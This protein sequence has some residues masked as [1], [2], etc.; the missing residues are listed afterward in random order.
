MN[1]IEEQKT[2]LEVLQS[3]FDGDQRFVVISDNKFQ[4]KFGQDGDC[5]S[6]ILE[7]S[8]PDTYP[9]TVPDISLD[10]FY[11]RHILSKVK[12]DIKARLLAE[13]KQY[14]GMAVTFTLFEYIRE[15]FEDLVKD[16]VEIYETDNY[17]ELNDSNSE[18]T[19]EDEVQEIT[20]EVKKMQMTKAQ[21]RRMWDHTVASKFGEKERGWNWV[22]IIKHLSQTRDND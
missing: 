5:K 7:I 13:A 22:D 11:N 19:K 16:Q 14:E 8:W 10:L 4:Y 1:V 18:T 3:I 12:N 20:G 21:K 9:K 6:F 17:K 2:E 15:N